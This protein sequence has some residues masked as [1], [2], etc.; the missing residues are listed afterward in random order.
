MGELRRTAGEEAAAD[1]VLPLPDLLQLVAERRAVAV[2]AG[3]LHAHGLGILADLVP[4]ERHQVPGIAQLD[5][6][7]ARPPRP[8]RRR[9]DRRRRAAACGKK[10]KTGGRVG[11][12]KRR[13]W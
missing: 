1:R 13:T 7:R 4:F 10:E 8:V 6:R 11:L 12:E 9:F 5:L 2:V 3:P